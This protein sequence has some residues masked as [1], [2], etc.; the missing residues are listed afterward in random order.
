MIIHL[1]TRRNRQN[2]FKS[3]YELHRKRTKESFEARSIFAG[4][5]GTALHTKK[6]V[7]AC[8]E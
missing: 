8:S 7:R 3:S 5:R 2:C 6:Y 1:K 4:V